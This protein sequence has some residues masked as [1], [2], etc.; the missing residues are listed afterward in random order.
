MTQKQ[1]KLFDFIKKYIS[2]H[3]LSPSYKEMQVHMNLS[4]KSKSIIHNYLV[5]LE[6]LNVISRIPAK[7]RGVRLVD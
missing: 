2:N 7:W 5:Q 3:G 4:L 6:K 1:K